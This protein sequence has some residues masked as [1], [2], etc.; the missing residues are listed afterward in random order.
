LPSAQ[1]RSIISPDSRRTWQAARLDPPLISCVSSGS[2]SNRQKGDEHD[3]AKSTAGLYGDESP[4]PLEMDL[5]TCGACT[6]ERQ[7]R[8]DARLYG[9]LQ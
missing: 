4:R 9:G 5:V 7:K 8:F 3:P 1:P 6:A 2:R